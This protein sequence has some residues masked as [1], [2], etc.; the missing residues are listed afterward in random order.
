MRVQTL[1]AHTCSAHATRGLHQISAHRGGEATP[2]VLVVRS[3][4]IFRVHEVFETVH[5]PVSFEATHGV[6]K[7]RVNQPEERG[8]GRTVTQVWFVLNNNRS[9]VVATD[10][11]GESPHERSA[12]KRFDDGEIVERRVFKRQRQNSRVRARRETKPLVRRCA[13]VDGETSCAVDEGATSGC[14]P[15]SAELGDTRPKALPGST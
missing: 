12:N 9:T 2:R 1:H 10:C 13:F 14:K 15:G 5:S 4:K 3:L 6:V 8:H 11:H 7:F